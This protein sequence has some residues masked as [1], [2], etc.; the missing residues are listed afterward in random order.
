L[1]EDEI[2]A[3]TATETTALSGMKHY[4]AKY[5]CSYLYTLKGKIANAYID[6]PVPSA[7]FQTILNTSFTPLEYGSYPVNVKYTLP[8]KDSPQSIYRYDIDFKE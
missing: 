8:G 7:K 5:A 2:E 1:T 3:G 4:I 6:R